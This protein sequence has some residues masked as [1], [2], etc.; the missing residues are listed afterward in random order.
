[1]L[2][3][4][5]KRPVDVSNRLEKLGLT[6]EDLV[7]VVEA[8]VG[9]KAG[10]TDNDPPGARGWS[11]WRMGTRRLR[12][13][14][15]IKDGWEK[16]ETDQISGV[17]NKT[18]GIRIAVSNTDDGT[19]IDDGCHF[20]QNTC[21]KGAATDRAIHS[22]ESFMEA[23]D[24]SLKA[25]PLRPGQRA[26]GPIVMWYLCVY[27]EGD[28]FRAELSCPDGVDSGFFTGFVERI[29]LIDSEEGGGG[30]VRRRIDDDG[31]DG[32]EFDIPVSRK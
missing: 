15:L 19:G 2:G 32:S 26:P 9:A 7:D 1:M 13:V 29:F 4:I 28:E 11:S 17:L 18:F 6:R 24:A 12:E 5:I 23:L 27:C 8:M 16:D 31:G 3:K 22:N 21:Q 20:P 30:V 25:I 10:C 14:T